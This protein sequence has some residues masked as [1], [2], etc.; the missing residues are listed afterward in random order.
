[1]LHKDI[2][3]E[4]IFLNSFSPDPIRVDKQA[5]VR[6]GGVCLYFKESLPI[7]ERCD[8]QLIPETIVAEIR[9]NRKKIFF[10][11]SYCYPDRP[12]AEFEEYVKSLEN[13][14]ELIKKENP[15]ATVL[16]G[17][18]NARSPFF[19]QMTRKTV[20]VACFQIS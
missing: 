10:I 17:D 18:F 15:V 6:N 20:M 19:G 7:I 13:I 2:T 8:L 16:S 12:I 1:M 11:L 4:D 5:N 9:L 3:K 14:C